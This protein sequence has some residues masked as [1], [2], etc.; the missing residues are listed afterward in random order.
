MKRIILT[1]ILFLVFLTNLKASSDYS[2]TVMDGESGR[3]LASKNENDS[4][5]VASTTKIMTSI[6]ALENCDT[7]KIVQVGEEINSVDGSMIYSHHN[8]KFK[9]IDLLY[10]LNLVSGNDA[11]MSIATSCLGYDKF[12]HKM[13]EKASEIGMK[14]TIFANPHG[15][16]E[17]TQN[18]STS[19]D[20]SI[21]MKYALKNKTFLLITNTKKYTVKTEEYSYI[22]YNK[23][24]LLDMYKFT[25]GGKVGYTPT[26]GHILVS[27]AS[28]NGKKLVIST[29]KDS[30]KFNNHVSLYEKYFDMYEEYKLIDKNNFVIDDYMYKN[31]YLY[32]LEDYDVL[33]KKDDNVSIK[34][35]LF[36]NIYNNKAGYIDIYIN[37]KKEYSQDVYA[38]KKNK[39]SLVRK[40][41]N[42]F[43]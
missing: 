4:H 16:D 35:I 41:L 25:T 15:L 32:V 3:V 17:I 21:L 33:L 5:L 8:E 24:K 11:A 31:Y 10:G 23:N 13:N 12:I 27:S 37:G 7:N 36:K 18:Y 29:I 14:N 34:Y 30:D 6:I 19:Y 39:M 38:V 20:L 22:W 1:I 43:K 9:L 42:L 28:K 26:S 2:F 40:L